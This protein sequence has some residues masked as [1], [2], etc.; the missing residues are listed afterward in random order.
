ML[1]LIL[2]LLFVQDGFAQAGEWKSKH[3]CPKGYLATPF[4]TRDKT[5]YIAK[6]DCAKA[7]NDNAKCRF[8]DLYWTRYGQTCYLRTDQ[9][10]DWQNNTH[11]SYLLYIKGGET[12]TP[13]PV[14]PT[15][16]PVTPTPAPADVECPEEKYVNTSLKIKKADKETVKLI[17]ENADPMCECFDKCKSAE[18]TYSYW[19][20]SMKRNKPIC[21]CYGEGKRMKLKDQSGATSGY[22]TDKGKTMI[23]KK[24]N[25]AR[26]TRRR[27]RGD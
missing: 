21:T 5:L 7:C 26:R 14:T 2:F 13:A 9:C 25:R 18:T 23:E 15:P 27:R 10:G 17:I 4:R 11:G 16:A 1:V 12:P 24:K 20:Y 3:K 8:A 19:A 22:L 6:R